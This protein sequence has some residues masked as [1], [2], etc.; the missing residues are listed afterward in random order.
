[1]SQS[2]RI[3]SDPVRRISWDGYEV[4]HKETVSKNAEDWL[5]IIMGIAI[6]KDIISFFLHFLSWELWTALFIFWYVGVV[7]GDIGMNRMSRAPIHIFHLYC[8]FCIVFGVALGLYMI[9]MHLTVWFQLHDPEKL[10]LNNGWVPNTKESWWFYIRPEDWTGLIKFF[11]GLIC[12]VGYCLIVEPLLH[13]KAI[14]W[15][16]VL[17]QEWEVEK[18]AAEYKGADLYDDV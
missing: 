12:S 3:P 7:I 9:Q 15:T 5:N 11:F 4:S 18:A 6:F 2:F 8:C 1:M 17:M 16:H 13:V 14:Y 10:K